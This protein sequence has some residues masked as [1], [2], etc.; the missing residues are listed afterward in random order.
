MILTKSI[1]DG[2][3][4]IF[5]DHQNKIILSIIF[6]F[7]FSLRLI[8]I[9]WDS[10]Y[11]FHPDERAIMMHGYDISFLSLKSLDFFNSE[12]STLNPKWFNYG[13]FPVYFVKIVSIFSNF[14]SNT[15][16]YDLRIPLRIFSAL[17]DSI[18]IIFL[19]KLE[20]LFKCH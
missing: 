17:I 4:K 19:Y 14:F 1:S 18:T 12:I 8:G 16:I 7:G 10:G 2:L 20:T 15:S 11:L 13:S 9:N 6:I 5:S 3:N